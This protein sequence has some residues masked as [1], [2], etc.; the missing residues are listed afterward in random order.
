MH[1]L[2]HILVA[3]LIA[4]FYE[5]F[6]RALRAIF[7]LHKVGWVGLFD[8]AGLQEVQTR[9]WSDALARM[10]REG[11]KQMG[12]SGQLRIAAK[13]VKRWGI[14]GLVRIDSTERIFRS[15]HLGYAIVVSRKA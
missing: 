8:Q 15:K 7:F 1:S 11:R 12:I 9:D 13:V 14:G 5:C 2:S 10:S 6:Q 3:E 4:A